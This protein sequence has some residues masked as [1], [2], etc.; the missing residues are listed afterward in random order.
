MHGDNQG[1]EGSKLRLERIPVCSSIL[2]EGLNENTSKDTIQL[3]FESNRHSG[4][5]IVSHVER[6]TKSSAVVH[7]EKASGS[8]VFHL[9]FRSLNTRRNFSEK[10]QV[11]YS[12]S[13]H[14]RSCHRLHSY[15]YKIGVIIGML[16]PERERERDIR[17][18]F[19]TALKIM[20]LSRK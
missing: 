13:Q 7:F 14:A 17:Y 2:V 3:Y 19:Q 11:C 15:P 4:G 1:P 8:I 12:S 5:D 20:G 18:A 10:K 6:I 16:Q 9:S